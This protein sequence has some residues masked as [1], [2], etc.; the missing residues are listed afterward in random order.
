VYDYE[1]ALAARKVVRDSLKVKPGEVV[2]V[3]ADT[4]SDEEVV[5]ATAA[6]PPRK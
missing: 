5:R 6:P 3:T 2:A 1:L 4:L